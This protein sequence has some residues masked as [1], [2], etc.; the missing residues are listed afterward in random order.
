MSLSLYMD[1]Q[2]P[3]AITEGL[4]AR[5]IDVLT[6]QEDAMRQA[7]DTVVLARA[8][9]L[10]RVTFSRDDDFLREAARCQRSGRHFA[11]VI[12][13]HQLRLS[14][15]RCVEDLELI[16]TACTPAEFANRVEFLPL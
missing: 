6:V 5:G 2:V 12:Y 1:E 15:G 14:V 13:A 9:D 16:A 7:E 3:A 4:R 11:G 10:G 8:A